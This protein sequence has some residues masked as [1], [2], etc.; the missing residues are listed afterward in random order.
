MSLLW[1]KTTC[2]NPLALYIERCMGLFSF[3]QN[4]EQLFRFWP[5]SPFLLEIIEGRYA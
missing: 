4:L 2:C 5:M 3:I 1:N